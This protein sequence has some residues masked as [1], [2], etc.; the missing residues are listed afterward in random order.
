MNGRRV[1][2]RQA[3][4]R[5]LAAASV[6]A[7][8]VLLVSGCSSS[9][10]DVEDRQNNAA[11]S[12]DARQDADGTVPTPALTPETGGPVPTGDATGS[13]GPAGTPSPSVPAA[14]SAAP[15]VKLPDPATVDRNDSVSVGKA[16]LTVMFSYDTVADT[17]RRDAQ[18]RAAPY[19][20]PDYLEVLRT[21]TKPFVDDEWRDW[22]S[23]QAHT[24]PTVEL[25]EEVADYV[26]DQAT[27][28]LRTFWVTVIAVGKDDWT[29]LGD[30]VAVYVTLTRAGPGSPWLLA[31]TDIQ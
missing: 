2:G 13:P 20:T 3:R 17:S 24:E 30:E 15:T 4:P 26:R 29:G 25:S 19:L 9:L 6:L 5:R 22:T 16:A 8:A 31:N 28:S 23:H 11:K 12:A 1:N 21:P 18:L 14:P 7:A 10:G 27:T